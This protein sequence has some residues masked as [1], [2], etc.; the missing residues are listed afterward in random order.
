M[1]NNEIKNTNKYQKLQEKVSKRISPFFDAA[2]T[3]EIYDQMLSGDNSYI[4]YSRIENAAYDE[5]W[6]NEIEN[7][8][9]DLGLIVKNPRSV[10]QVVGDVVPVELA[11]K[12]NGESVQHLA[13]HSQ[14]VKEI[15]DKGDVI[16]NKILNIGS[17]DFYKTYEN[18]FVATLIRKLTLFIEKRC[19]FIDENINIRKSEILMYKN[20]SVIDGKEVEIETKVKVIGD[21][22]RPL[23]EDEKNKDFAQRVEQVRRYVLYF[24]NSEFMKIMK[25]EKNVR[26]P[27]LMTN[28]IRKNPLYNHCY[29]LYKY[30][31][32]YELL[33]VDFKIDDKYENLSKEELDEINHAMMVNF[34]ALKAESSSLP[35]KR[36]ERK[37]FK[38]K[39]LTTIDDE[40]F[41][42]GPW[43]KGPFEFTRID[44]DFINSLRRKEKNAAS[45]TK[46]EREFEKE[47]LKKNE[48]LKRK[49]RLLE[50]VAA[51][52]AKLAIALD[53]KF[54]RIADERRQEDIKRAQE[55]A[56]RASQQILDEIEIA[57]RALI[58]SVI[59]EKNQ[60][61]AL[62]AA[63]KANKNNFNG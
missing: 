40:E 4:K 9:Y 10:T 28:I 13:T 27:I 22:D 57:R 20:K 48:K 37:S 44:D 29:R 38:P 12:T 43:M 19:Q 54:E 35:P 33:G 18:R 49:I 53:K 23:N 31:E 5:S 36:F 34:L 11:R 15:N 6:L 30:I 7:C 55:A 21:I 39:V 58:K 59:D 8:I 14:Y 41:V 62:K 2:S 50:R 63:K 60:E 26:N 56:R 46:Q 45:S 24:Y 16:P 32:K 3:K 1:E 17:D 51:K 42:Y 25:T 61:K 47:Q 52:K